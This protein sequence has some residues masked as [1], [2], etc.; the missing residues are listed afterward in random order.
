MAIE[1]RGASVNPPITVNAHHKYFVF[2]GLAPTH[3]STV[4]SV[5]ANGVQ[6]REYT[7]PSANGPWAGPFGGLAWTAR[8][9]G[10]CP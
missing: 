10:V 1:W 6:V 4:C 8:L 3:T 2:Q 9:D 7:A 5:A